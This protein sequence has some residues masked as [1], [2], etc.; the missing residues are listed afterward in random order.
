MLKKVR[1]QAEERRIRA[2][3]PE[4]QEKLEKLRQIK[5]ERGHKIP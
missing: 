2:E 5:R 1:K 4:R 3:S